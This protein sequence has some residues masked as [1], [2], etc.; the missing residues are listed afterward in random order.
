MLTCLLWPVHICT[1]DNDW[2]DCDRPSA[3]GYNS[4]ERLDYL[5]GLF[6][7]TN[8]SQ[9]QK[10]LKQEVQTE[11]LCLNAANILV[12]CV[13]NR[14]W[15]LRGVT[16]VTLN[17]AGSCNNLCDT[18]AGQYWSF[19]TSWPAGSLILA[20]PDKLHTSRCPFRLYGPLYVPARWPL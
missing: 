11:A 19:A 10:T 3:G 20:V 6:F 5:R 13:E 15:A 2:T 12:P 17:V 1:G 18:G 8:R 16:Y 14:R 7:S 4:R 9:G